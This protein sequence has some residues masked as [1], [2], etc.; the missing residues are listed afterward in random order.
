MSITKIINDIKNSSG[1]ET[2]LSRDSIVILFFRW[3][4]F[5]VTPF[6]IIINIFQFLFT[7]KI[8]AGISSRLS[9]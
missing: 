1:Q 5:Y 3:L 7:Y 8:A 9:S 2:K 4:S 6:F